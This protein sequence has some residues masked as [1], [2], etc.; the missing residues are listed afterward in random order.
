MAISSLNP[1]QH[2]E[3]NMKQYLDLLKDV[4]HNGEIQS[5]RTKTGIRS[6]F[7]R[8]L[9]FNLDDGFPLL[10]TKHCHLH[11][12]VHE[13]LWFLSGNT[14]IDYLN[15]HKV[16]I[17]DEWAHHDGSLGPIYG[18]QW[19]SWGHGDTTTIDQISNVISSIKN[20]PYSRRHIVSSWNVGELEKWL[21][22]HAIY[23][24][25]SM[26]ITTNYR[27]SYISVVQISF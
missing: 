19:R 11:S 26:F 27:A 6:V 7:G 12:I 25:S 15:K 5:D 24:F 16:K 4:L 13:L 22:H 18:K 14:N 10:T 23:F 1:P 3:N 2:Q 21:Y 9:R 17:W 20:D 8:Q